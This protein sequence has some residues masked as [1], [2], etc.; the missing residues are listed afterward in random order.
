MCKRSMIGTQYKRKSKQEMTI[1]SQ[2]VHDRG[3][4]ATRSTVPQLSFGER[5]AGVA[6]DFQN[7][8]LHLLKYAALG[9][10]IRISV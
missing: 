8:I 7:T 6:D 1:T 5:F 9:E 3:K 4:F 2:A 10:L